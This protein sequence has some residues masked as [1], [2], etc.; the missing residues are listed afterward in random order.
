MY[1]NKHPVYIFGDVSQP[2]NI[3][4]DGD[5]RK[6]TYKKFFID[7]YRFSNY[8]DDYIFIILFANENSKRIKCTFDDI[9]EFDIHN[10]RKNISQCEIE[11]DIIS[12]EIKRDR[13]IRRGGHK[14]PVVKKEINGKLRCI[15]TIA[16]SR[17][18]HLK[19]KGRLI[20]VADYKKLMKKT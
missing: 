14:A 2:I 11:D 16:G 20:T 12:V 17:K 19:Y 9:Y 8:Y 7:D 1:S 10:R 5:I 3:N 15:Y 13:N 4:Y 18:E 6:M